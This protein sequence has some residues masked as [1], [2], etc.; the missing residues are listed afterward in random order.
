[1]ASIRLPLCRVRTEVH[2][3]CHTLQGVV[4]YWQ[5]NVRGVYATIRESLPYLT[6]AARVLVPTGRVAREPQSGIGTY[7]VSKAGAEA[8]ARGFAVDT[9]YTVGALDLDQLATELT[10]GHGRDPSTIGPMFYWAATAADPTPLDGSVTDLKTWKQE[11][12]SR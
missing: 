8:V 7:A 3:E 1:M 6:G 12:R 11:T 2:A 5:T 4:A 10:G 9:E